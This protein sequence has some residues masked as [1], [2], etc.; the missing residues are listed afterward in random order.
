MSILKVSVEFEGKPSDVLSASQVMFRAFGHHYFTRLNAR[1]ELV[2]QV[3][4]QEKDQ[5]SRPEH[6]LDKGIEELELGVR[7]FNCL[8]RVG[9]ETIGDL[10]A[11]SEEELKGIPNFGKKPLDEVVEKLAERGLQLR[12]D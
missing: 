10:T 4:S 3:L 9:I 8:K 1:A 5:M 6:F 12:Q 7:G 11:K 2:V